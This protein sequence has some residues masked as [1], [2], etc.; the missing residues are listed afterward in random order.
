MNLDMG[1]CTGIVGESRSLA[2][3]GDQGQTMNQV[4]GSD[5]IEAIGSIDEIQSALDFG[6]LYSYH[7]LVIKKIETVQ[8]QLRFLAGELLGF[9]HKTERISQSDVT[10][11]TDFIDEVRHLIDKEFARYNTEPSCWLNEARVRVRK[12][13]RALSTLDTSPIIKRY[14]N[15][16]SDYL[17]I[18]SDPKVSEFLLNKFEF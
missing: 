10:E 3:S 12:T 9:P 2:S 7:T 15:R 17:F 1:T 11:M 5:M 18:L 6:R 8:T 13:E 14:I 4:K 16:L